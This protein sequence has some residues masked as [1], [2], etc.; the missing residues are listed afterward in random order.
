M[1]VD[2][3]LFKWT[4]WVQDFPKE[5]P[6]LF[7]KTPEPEKITIFILSVNFPTVKRLELLNSRN[8][9]KENLKKIFFS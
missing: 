5:V 8:A 2:L 9:H 1:F 7:K 4:L 6:K 3:N